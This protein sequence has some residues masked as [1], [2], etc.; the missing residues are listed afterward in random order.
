MHVLYGFFTEC[1]ETS[2]DLRDIKAYCCVSKL[3]KRIAALL[4]LL[5]DGPLSMFPLY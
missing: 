2:R 3:L 4:Y 1:L 5:D